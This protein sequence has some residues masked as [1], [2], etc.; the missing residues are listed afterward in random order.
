MNVFNG[1]I[2]QL[3]KIINQNPV[4]SQARLFRRGHW[5]TVKIA[6]CDGKTFFNEQGE[7]VGQVSEPIGFMG[8]QRMLNQ[9]E[10]EG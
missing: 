5:V 7:A 3:Q 9:R 6:R 10:F 2:R 1:S 8:P 4:S